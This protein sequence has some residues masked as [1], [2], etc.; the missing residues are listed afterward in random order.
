MPRFKSRSVTVSGIIETTILEAS[1]LQDLLA[2]LQR[3]NVQLIY[4]RRLILDIPP[5]WQKYWTNFKPELID[6]CQFAAS[7]DRA[8]VALPDILSDARHVVRN[9]KLAQALLEIRSQVREGASLSQALVNFSYIFDAPFIQMIHISEQTGK[10][11]Q[12]FDQLVEHLKWEVSTKSSLY[13]TIRYPLFVLLTLMMTFA[14]LSNFLLPELKSFLSAA[15]IQMQWHTRLLFHVFEYGTELFLMLFVLLGLLA[16]LC[17]FLRSISQHSRFFFDRLVLR[18]PFLGTYINHITFARFF[19]YFAS[20]FSSGIDVLQ[21][22]EV[23]IHFLS[24][25]FLIRELK[26]IRTLIEAGG[27]LAESFATSPICCVSTQRLLY[28]GESTG[29]LH[30]FLSR[31]R[32]LH[33]AAAKRKLNFLISNLEPFLLFLAG[34]FLLWIVMAIFQPI[35]TSLTLLEP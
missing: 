12:A 6:F 2:L 19:H 29:Q 35:Y 20:T 5:S 28:A 24:N 18:T 31:I 16:G 34:A 33:E 22:L 32:D 1:S 4:A 11:H 25:R 30:M 17:A 21:C 26:M 10:L 9:K 27:S 8:G 23:S 14:A 7:M 15:H 13:A 3:E